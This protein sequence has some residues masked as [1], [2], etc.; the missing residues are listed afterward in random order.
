MKPGSVKNTANSLKFLDYMVKLRNEA[1]DAASLQYVRE[2]VDPYAQ[3]LSRASKKNMKEEDLPLIVSIP[4][5]ED[6]T[7][8]PLRV[9]T[10]CQSGRCLQVLLTAENLDVFARIAQVYVSEGMGTQ[11]RPRI[12]RA[13]QSSTGCACIAKEWDVRRKDEGASV[14]WCAYRTA[15]VDLMN[16]KRHR[17][18]YSADVEGDME[19]AVRR[20]VAVLAEKHHVPLPDGKMVLASTHGLDMFSPGGDLDAAGYLDDRR[21]EQESAESSAEGRGDHD[22]VLSDAH[23]KSDVD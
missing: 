15:N 23:P 11:R 5:V 2:N 6:P 18:E 22:E 4:N 16:K 12:A 21:G 9:K 17:E 8:E 3:K 7:M 19:K 13:Q 10:T 14:V 1:V 20:C